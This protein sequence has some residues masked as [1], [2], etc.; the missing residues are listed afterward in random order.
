METALWLQHPPA[1]P[2]T[3]H[4]LKT[5]FSILPMDQSDHN[6]RLQGAPRELL[7]CVPEKPPSQGSSSPIV[8]A[9]N[10]YQ[11]NWG[12]NRIPTPFL[13]QINEGR[14]TSPAST[15][16]MADFHPTSASYIR[17]GY[18]GYVSRD[19]PSH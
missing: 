12:T 11:A 19:T 1:A 17:Y 10:M 8:P 18:A 16:Y 2:L 7:G 3:K 5:S 13:E 6:T 15:Q 9:N 4:N 14:G